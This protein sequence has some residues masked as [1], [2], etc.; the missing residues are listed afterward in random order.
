MKSFIV[1]HLDLDK[2][3]YTNQS[4]ASSLLHVLEHALQDIV[5]AEIKG[6]DLVTWEKKNQKKRTISLFV[7]L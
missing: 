4:S 6:K 1:K 2:P 7:P 3:I 5:P